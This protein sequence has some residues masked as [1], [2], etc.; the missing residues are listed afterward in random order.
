MTSPRLTCAVGEQE[1]AGDDDTH[2]GQHVADLGAREPHRAQ[3]Q[4][5]ALGLDPA[6]DVLVGAGDPARLQPERLDRARRRGGLADGGVDLAERRHLGAVALVGALAVPPRAEHDRRRADQAG[7]G[8]QRRRDDG[9][10]ADQ[11]H[12]Q[13][14]HADL[15]CGQP[16]GVREVLDVGGR[17]GHQV[18]GAGPLDRAEREVRGVLEEVLAQL[19]EH[20]LAEGGGAVAGPA[21]EQRLYDERAGE[22]QRQPV[23]RRGGHA[24]A[25]ALDD[26][27]EHAR[28]DQPG[29]HGAGVQAEREQQRAAVPAHQDADLLEH[30]GSRGDRQLGAHSS[31]PRVTRSR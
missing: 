4:R 23:D 5:V 1:A 15:R 17:A 20:G 26:V 10:R 22:D 6:A 13:Q 2:D 25:D 24:G 7:S 12:R 21:G 19:G 11:Q 27:A 29:E 30:L 18:A 16:H 14:G 28:A 31:S 9:R 3:P 8:E